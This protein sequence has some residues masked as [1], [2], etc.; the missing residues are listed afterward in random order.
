MEF[1]LRDARRIRDAWSCLFAAGG[2]TYAARASLAAVGFKMRRIEGDGQIGIGMVLEELMSG[3]VF[4]GRG[5]SMGRAF[6][7][8][9]NW[10]PD[11]WGFAPGWYGTGLW[12]SRHRV[13]SQELG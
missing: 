3:A 11:T 5:A 10:C 9:V 7:A 6:S 2:G 4:R 12:P 13:G 1:R 8:R